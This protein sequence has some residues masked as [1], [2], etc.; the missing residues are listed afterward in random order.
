MPSRRA[1]LPAEGWA[2]SP[3]GWWGAQG[4]SW[5]CAKG[6]PVGCSG[7]AELGG[8][9]S[10]LSSLQGLFPSWGTSSVPE[11]PLHHGGPR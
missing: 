2:G 6:P 11:E 4:C 7:E 10:Q 1:L 9:C 8:V 3:H 5:V